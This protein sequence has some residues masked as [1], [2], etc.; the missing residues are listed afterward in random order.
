MPEL[1]EVEICARQ[2]STHLRGRTIRQVE[3]RDHK[4]HLPQDL[5]GHVI[6]EIYRRGKFIILRLDDGRR[7]LIHLGMTGWFEFT[8]PGRY[9]LAIS[10]GDDT[11]YFEDLRL[12]GKAH[13]VS[14]AQEQAVLAKLGPG[15]LS[16]GFD[17]AGLKWTRR[18]KWRCWT[19]NWWQASATCMR[20]NPCGAPASTPSALPTG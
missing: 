18:S 14:A 19:N 9:R 10:T 7:I 3:V 4:L 5:E 16:R 13:G 2:L 20:S 1:P 6:A 15:P 17:L 11:A 12:F 8:P